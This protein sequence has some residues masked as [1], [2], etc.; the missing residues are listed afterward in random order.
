MKAFSCRI[1]ID[2]EDCPVVCE[3]KDWQVGNGVLLHKPT[4]CAFTIEVDE[5]AILFD[6]GLKFAL[7]ARMVTGRPTQRKQVELGRAAITLMLR[8]LEEPKP[9][10]EGGETRRKHAPTE[11]GQAD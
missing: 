11:S 1:R 10:C 3:P 4:G 6:R 5:N 9:N 2:A 7:L 8:M